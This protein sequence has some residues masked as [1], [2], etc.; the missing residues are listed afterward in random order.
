MLIV[1]AWWSSR[2]RIA[3]ARTWSL[4]ISP[5]SRKLLLLVEMRLARSYRRGV[6]SA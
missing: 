2:S 4:K 5:Q 1:V 3:V 6:P